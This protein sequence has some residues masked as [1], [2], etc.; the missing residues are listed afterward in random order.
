VLIQKNI[1]R[2][3]Q[4]VHIAAS[5]ERR[6][7][8]TVSMVGWM[9]PKLE[10]DGGRKDPVH[11]RRG[12]RPS[13]AVQNV[14]KRGEWA[15]RHGGRDVGQPVLLADVSDDELTPLASRRRW[16]RARC[17]AIG[18]SLV[19]FF[20]RRVSHR[21]S[22]FGAAP[23]CLLRSAETRPSTPA[24]AQSEDVSPRHPTGKHCANI[25]TQTKCL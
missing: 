24:R 1:D 14:A 6:E 10:T 19:A 7:T 21:W 9:R 4:I 20:D 15:A 25:R 23:S 3:C 16:T 18:Q 11:A 22:S 17:R 2:L 5:A 8:K 13:V 12:P